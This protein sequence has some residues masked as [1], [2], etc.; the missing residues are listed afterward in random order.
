MIIDISEGVFL[1]VT[2]K[3]NWLSIFLILS[4]FFSGEV[5]IPCDLNAVPPSPEGKL[6]I[7]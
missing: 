7:I 6:Q 4:S 5:T 2:F 3:R 1:I